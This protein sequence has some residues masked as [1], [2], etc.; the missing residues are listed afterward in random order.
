MPAVE[1]LPTAGLPKGDL[2]QPSSQLRHAGEHPQEGCGLLPVSD[3]PA[4]DLPYSSLPQGPSPREGR[5]QALPPQGRSAALSPSPC[6]PSPQPGSAA[7]C[8][9]LP[10]ELGKPLRWHEPS[11]LRS[12]AS[13]S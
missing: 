13:Q 4:I 6:P 8:T 12:P 2:L 3:R 11:V 10:G 5:P 9:S 1:L 7:V